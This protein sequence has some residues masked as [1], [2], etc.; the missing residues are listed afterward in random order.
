MFTSYN[1][2]EAA[3]LSLR[4]GPGQPLGT[5]LP[6][7]LAALSIPERMREVIRRKTRQGQPTTRDDFHGA[8]ETCDLSDAELDTNIGAAS[9]LASAEAVR[10]DQP[11][12]PVHPWDFDPDYRRERVARGAEII[13]G[14]LPDAPA[15]HLA[16]RS[17]GFATREVGDLWP[18]LI[19]AA[20]HGFRTAQVR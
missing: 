1:I 5:Y 20:A 13:G 15:I 19:E 16:L 11:T 10:H 9:R 7:A 14:L 12:A 8:E 6:P 2:P 18:E 4:S 17:A 3:T